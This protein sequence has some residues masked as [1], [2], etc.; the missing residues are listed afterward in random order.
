MRRLL[1]IDDSVDLLFAMQEILSYYHYT[2]R[3][4]S[5]SNE[6]IKELETF[7]PELI[8]I[9]VLLSGE[10][11]RDLCKQLRE[12]PNTKNIAIILFSASPKHLY[13]FEECGADGI[14]EK[15]FGVHELIQKIKTTIERKIINPY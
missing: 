2:T 11:G 14:I 1:I 15:P 9:D 8:L 7:N 4:A 10:N 5:N 3:T 6:L 13:N 12:N